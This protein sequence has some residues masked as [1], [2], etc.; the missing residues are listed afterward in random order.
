LQTYATTDFDSIFL[1]EFLEECKKIQSPFSQ[2][3]SILGIKKD[4]Q[5]NL[6][7]LVVPEAGFEKSL[8]Q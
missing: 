5:E 2:L 3:F 1:E 6:E 8:L 7:S 4:F